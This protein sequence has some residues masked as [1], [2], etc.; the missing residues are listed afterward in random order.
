[1]ARRL[2]RRRPGPDNRVRAENITAYALPT[3]P[4]VRLSDGVSAV[5]LTPRQALSLARELQQAAR[6]AELIE[7]RSDG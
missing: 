4:M 7:A 6:A 2:G 3:R 5:E 1:M